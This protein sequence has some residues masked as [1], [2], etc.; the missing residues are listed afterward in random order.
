MNFSPE[1][2]MVKVVQVLENGE[3]VDATYTSFLELSDPSE[4]FTVKNY[5]YEPKREN[6]SRD[7]IYHEIPITDLVRVS[8]NTW[9]YKKTTKSGKVHHWIITKSTLSLTL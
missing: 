3:L 9:E 2:V 1:S 8:R 7:W 5:E 4:G 6:D